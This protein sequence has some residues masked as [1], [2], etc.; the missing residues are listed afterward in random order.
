MTTVM[1]GAVAGLIGVILGGG[2]RAVEAFFQ[3]KTEA[4]SLL[5]A[6]VAEVE[7]VTRLINHRGFV[8]ALIQA[9]A[10]A[11]QLIDAG[12]GGEIADFLTI[13]L[14]QRYF[15]VFDAS[16]AKLGILD[17]YHADRI[18]RFY[19]YVK[20]ISENYDA[21]SPFQ[22]DIT[23]D[24]VAMVIESD[25]PLLHT[26]ITLGNHI[27]T[28]RPISAPSGVTDPFGQQQQALPGNDPEIGQI[29]TS[30]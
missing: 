2:V 27:A 3:R 6:L 19:T 14:K 4:A 22:Q 16:V 13:N 24:M 8:D 12:R 23:A 29:P 1:I 17:T 30:G 5:S 11:R 9:H 15:A 25:L 10:N 21:E 28:F 18:V 26:V 20:A 7:A